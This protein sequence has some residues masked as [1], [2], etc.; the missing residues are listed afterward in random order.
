VPYLNPGNYE[1]K[2]RVSGFR[3]YPHR[4]RLRAGDA[5]RIDLTLELGAVTESVNV[6]GGSAAPTGSRQPLQVSVEQGIHAHTD[7]LRT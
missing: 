3:T 4:H 7:Q 5:P 1:M 6:R 2:V